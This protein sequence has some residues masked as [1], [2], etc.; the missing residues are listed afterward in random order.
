MNIHIDNDWG[1]VI[2]SCTQGYHYPPDQSAYH[3][4]I[5]EQ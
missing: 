4:N 1:E 3:V 2:E 5:Q